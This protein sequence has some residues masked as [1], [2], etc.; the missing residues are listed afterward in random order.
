[1]RFKKGREVTGL[2][3][4]TKHNVEVPYDEIC[5]MLVDC[6]SKD[7]RPLAKDTPGAYAYT[8][9]GDTDS[10][11]IAGQRPAATE[12]YVKEDLT[13][14]SIGISSQTSIRIQVFLAE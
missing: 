5:A 6:K 3:E 4:Q 7:F 1:M 13:L 8:R 14:S 9:T 2:P 11:F 10:Y 12:L